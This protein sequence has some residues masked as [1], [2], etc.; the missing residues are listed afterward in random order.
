MIVEVFLSVLFLLLV[1]LLGRLFQA[2]L[3]YHRLCRMVRP[4]PG[5]PTHWLYGNLPQKKADN[6]DLK[7]YEWV[8]E[9]R[10]SVSKEWIGPFTVLISIHDPDVLMSLVKTPK[11]DSMYSLFDPWLGRGLLLASGKR[12]ARNRRL[13][14][15]AFHFDILKPYVETYNIAVDELI[16]N[17]TEHARNTPNTPLAAYKSIAHL[18]LDILLRC[19]FSYESNCQKE[20]VDSPYINAVFSLS[21]LMLERF[22][23][24]FHFSLHNTLYMYCTSSGREFKRAC[25]VV[26]EHADTIIKERKAI[27]G[28]KDSSG[29]INTEE[30]LAQAKRNHKRLDFIDI[31]LTAR[32]ERG[33][34]LTEREV[35]YEVDT[36]TFEGFDTTAHGLCWT[37]YC[38]A[39][40]PEHQDKCRE[41]VNEVLGD[42]QYVEYDDL[43]R[44]PYLTSCIKEALRLFPPVYIITRQLDA[45]TQVGEHLLPKDMM[46]FFRFYNIH[47]HPKHWK[48]PEQYNPLRF[49]HFNTDSNPFA[50]VPFS[51]GQRN[52]IGQHFT[53]NNERVIL[54][55]IIRQFRFKMAD[56]FEIDTLF[57]ILIHLK[58][59]IQLIIEPLD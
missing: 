26:H 5:W 42:R 2:L 4:V 34:G 27:L 23:N 32:D 36:F 52:C 9:N 19:S 17:W 49:A 37:L 31:L 59:D 29:D 43:A 12:W 33:E 53:M 6:Y 38:L 56:G 8:K 1:Y 24:L 14:T 44:L 20:S 55:R 7:L 57:G 11:A 51:A 50:Y 39:T 54:A 16:A 18:T 46:M 45:D 41:E 30:V 35:R 48:D 25:D 40:H 22:L 3:A 15:G 13:L 58:N 47:R 28:L 21:R 10:V